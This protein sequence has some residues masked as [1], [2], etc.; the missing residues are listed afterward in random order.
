MPVSYEELLTEVV[1]R[2]I[3]S[4][5]GYDRAMKQIEGL[6]RKSAKSRAKDDMIAL[7]ATLI[8]QYEI[9]QGFSDPV[10]APRDRLAGAP[11]GT[12]SVDASPDPDPLTPD[13]L[14]PDPDPLIPL[15]ADDIA[16]EEIESET[17][18]EALAEYQ[19]AVEALEKSRESEVEAARAKLVADLNAAQEQAAMAN[20]LDDAVRI[21]KYREGVE[22]EAKAAKLKLAW[23]PGTYELKYFPNQSSCTVE[24]RP[25]GDFLD[26]ATG[27]GSSKLRR[28]RGDV[29]RDAPPRFERITF[30]PNYFFAE[31]FFSREDFGK[32]IVNQIGVGQKVDEQA[33]LLSDIESEEAHQAVEAFQEALDDLSKSAEKEKSSARRSLFPRLQAAQES[34]ATANQ[35]EEALRIRELV[36]A[37]EAEVK[38]HRTDLG[39][40]PGTYKVKYYPNQTVHTTVVQPNGDATLDDKFRGRLDRQGDAYFVEWGEGHFERIVFCD[41]RVFVEHYGTKEA[42][43]KHAIDHFGVGERVKGE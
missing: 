12:P 33:K 11:D 7:L 42:L 38:A 10:I 3:S 9:R 1:P 2:P 30:A 22:A 35:L 34:A 15:P 6:M 43:D 40:V 13:P 8:E 31:H 29:V 16:A 25:N 36:E 18:H 39:F 24:I 32:N 20:E 5:R 37:V 27:K 21:R 23:V 4:R 28:F 17:V 41:R 14:S 26:K 19:A